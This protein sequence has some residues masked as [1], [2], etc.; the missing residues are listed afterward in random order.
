MQV[1]ISSQGAVF[2]I[3][4]V[5]DQCFKQHGQITV[6]QLKRYSRAV[7]VCLLGLWWGRG[8]GEVQFTYFVCMMILNGGVLLLDIYH[9]Q[10]LPYYWLIV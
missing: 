6:T 4:Y 1:P 10:H 7:T 5:A 9:E 3:L 2:H 8:G